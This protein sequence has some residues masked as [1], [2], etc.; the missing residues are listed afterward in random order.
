M[1]SVRQILPEIN[2]KMNN[3]DQGKLSKNFELHWW[4]FQISFWYLLMS[5]NEEDLLITCNSVLS[6]LKAL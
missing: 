3:E 4:R 2:Q 5:K 6:A 1:H